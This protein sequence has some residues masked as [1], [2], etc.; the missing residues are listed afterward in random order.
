VTSEYHPLV[1]RLLDGEISLAELPAELHAQGEE[2]LRW[3][4]SLDR[5]PVTLQPGLDERVMARVRTPAASPLRRAWSA[6]MG[7]RDVRLRVRLGPLLAGAAVAATLLIGLARRPKPAEPQIVAHASS[8]V[9]VRF[10][11]YAPEAR[12]VALVGTFNRWDPNAPPLAPSGTPG[13]WAITVALPAGQHQYAFLLDGSKWVT[14]PA[15]PAVSDGF[16][17]RNS[18]VTV[19][20]EP[21]G[22]RAL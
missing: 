2:A 12:H 21:D 15:A 20:S 7:V 6:F 5:D 18:V 17:Q 9:Y 16:G 14:D 11:C 4:A 22:G 13:V 19:T 8:P 10:I 1:K 3:L